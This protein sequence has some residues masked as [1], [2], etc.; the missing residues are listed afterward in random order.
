MGGG[1]EEKRGRVWI[2]D[3]CGYLV[4]GPWYLMKMARVVWYK[5][6]CNMLQ[7]R[8]GGLWERKRC[9]YSNLRLNGRC[10]GGGGT[11]V[12]CML[13]YRGKS[14]VLVGT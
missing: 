4:P 5:V 10:G 2:S 8:G 3:R 13:G 1:E 14:E 6:A 9:T 11:R 7:G 12:C